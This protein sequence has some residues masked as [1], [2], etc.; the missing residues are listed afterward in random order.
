MTCKMVRLD[1]LTVE[2]FPPLPPID[3]IFAHVDPQN[4]MTLR[5]FFGLSIAFLLASSA[6]GQGRHVDIPEFQ[7]MMTMEGA[8]LIDVRTPEEFAKGHLDGA[9]NI[10]WLEDGFLE[11]AASLDPKKPVLLYCAAG[12]RSEDALNA[13][14]AAGY[15]NVV[16]LARGFNGWKAANLPFS[17]K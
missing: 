11:K 17:T 15:A 2:L 10:D 14:R 9:R 1:A 4:Q 7:K 13:L 6:F 16:D 3:P 5:T 12:G 8:Q